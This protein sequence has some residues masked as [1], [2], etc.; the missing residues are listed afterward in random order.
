MVKHISRSRKDYKRAYRLL[1]LEISIYDERSDIGL[2]EDA[3][4][5]A[6]LS[7][8]ERDSHFS[9]WINR[10]RLQKFHNRKF[11]LDPMREFPF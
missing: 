6:L 5:C 4:D 7:Y 8:D 9:G 1:R 11:D 3:W 2:C 10:Q